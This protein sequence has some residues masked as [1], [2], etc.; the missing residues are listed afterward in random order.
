MPVPRLRRGADVPDLIDRNALTVTVTPDGKDSYAL[1]LSTWPGSDTLRHQALDAIA[2]RTNPRL[3]GWRRPDTIRASLWTSRG[4]MAWCE[5][6][7]IESFAD[8]TLQHYEDWEEQ[9]RERYTINTLL[10]RWQAVRAFLRDTRVLQTQLLW[11]V[12]SRFEMARVEHDKV[13]LSLPQFFAVEKA[14]LRIVSKARFRVERAYAQVQEAMESDEPTPRQQALLDI[15]EGRHDLP[16]PGAAEHRRRRDLGPP[17]PVTG[18]NFYGNWF[19]LT[20]AETTAAAMLLVCR[21]GWNKSVTEALTTGSWRLIDDAQ[22]VIS[23]ALDKPRRRARRHSSE[24][25]VDYGPTSAGRAFA[26]VV[27]ATGPARA[28]A[29]HQGV[30]TNV[31]WLRASPNGEPVVGHLHDGLAKW[32]VRPWMP[33]EVEGVSVTF[34][35]LRR[36]H[37]ALVEKAPSQNSL[38]THLKKY[39]A[40]SD[41]ARAELDAVSAA[42]LESMLA[43]AEESLQLRMQAESEVSVEVAS[44]AKDTA[45][46]ACRD[47]NRHPETG[48]PCEESFLACLACKN[49]VATPRHLPRLVTLHKAMDDLR[50]NSTERAWRPFS[51][52][53][54][55]LHAFLFKSVGLA[56]ETYQRHMQAATPADQAAVHAVLNGDL[57]G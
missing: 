4:F 30:A 2:R 17:T 49:A 33:T 55:R 19:A 11:H 42:G 12:N 8:L 15:W 26:M 37:Q 18:N 9:E 5:A 21:A 52:H 46:A 27:D 10:T 16:T 25:L 56:D 53:Y 34:P 1:D 22:P 57:D 13:Y 24:V 28:W 54:L 40:A 43:R 41:E 29:A 45:T 23:L 44:G 20:S 50:C 51:E 32:D 7:G 31:L 3:N 36:T 39:I 35:V 47:I 48:A 6:E 38:G 14:A